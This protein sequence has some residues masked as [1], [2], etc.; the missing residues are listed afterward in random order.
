[1]RKR[2]GPSDCGS[3]RASTRKVREPS[4]EVARRAEERESPEAVRRN[5]ARPGHPRTSLLSERA[6]RAH[7]S[8]PSRR[9]WGPSG[10]GAGGVRARRPRPLRSRTSP[11]AGWGPSDPSTAGGRRHSGC[12]HPGVGVKVERCSPGGGVLGP[13]NEDLVVCSHASWNTAEE[14]LHSSRTAAHSG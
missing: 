11:V 13:R 7:C 3:V 5:C 14:F 6:P 4:R 9:G 12:G 1:M 8:R 2:S 10:P